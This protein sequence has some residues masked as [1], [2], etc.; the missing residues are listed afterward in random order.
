MRQMEY[1]RKKSVIFFMHMVKNTIYWSR[2]T[3]KDKIVKYL[4]QAQIMQP[5]C[6]LYTSREMKITFL[7]L[8]LN[9]GSGSFPPLLIQKFP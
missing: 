5:V 7:P 6:Q 1:Y 2:K 4:L 3:I 9:A 8:N